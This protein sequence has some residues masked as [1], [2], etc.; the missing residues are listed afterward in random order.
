MPDRFALMGHP[1]AHTRSPK[2]HALFAE[3]FERELEYSAIDVLPE[4]FAVEV[5]RFFAAGGKGLNVT[6]PHK[7]AAFALV[8]ELTPRAQ[9]AGSVNT[10]APLPNG[11]ILGDN[12]DGAGLLR[13]L[14]GRMGM[15][16]RGKRILLI[17]AGGAARG[18][19]AFLIDIKPVSLEIFNRGQPRLLE[20]LHDFTAYADEHGVALRAAAAGPYD[21][22][23][24]ATSA[25]HTGEL[26]QIP[27]AAIGSH[28]V[29]YDMGYGSEGTAFA[30][31][32]QAQGAARV[33]MGL[34]MLVEQAAEAFKLWHGLFPVTGP[35]LA[36]I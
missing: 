21:L 30:H 1:V 25:H 34:G 23:V 3:Q 13:D 33:E 4:N 18:A 26:P 31:W 35:V 16:L 22:V 7:Q 19:M 5:Q 9:R 32:A 14:C 6:V 20:L 28:T 27:P 2:I 10:L 17:G 29:C 24:N 11:K 15:H 8:D 36:A 12:T